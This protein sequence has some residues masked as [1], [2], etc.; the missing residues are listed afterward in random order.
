[1]CWSLRA[2]R[3]VRGSTD[4]NRPPWPGAIVTICMSCVRI[5]DPAKEHETNKPPPTGRVR[6]RSKGDTA[7][8]TTSQNPSLWHPSWLNK[9]YTT[10]KD[11]ESER[12][13]KDNPETNPIT[14]KPETASHAA[15][16]FSWVPL[17]YCSP[18]GCPFLI[19]SLALSTHV[20]PQTICFLVLDKSPVSGPGKGSPSCNSS[21]AFSESSLYIWK[22]SFH[23]LLKPNL[24]DFEHYLTSM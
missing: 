4:G 13:A 14:I 24:K 21:S 8:P 19:K 7:C 5:G 3:P 16:L 22:F 11:S 23:V 18:P 12:L 1:M 6:E 17:P 10:R 2:R 20:S 15:E 9:A